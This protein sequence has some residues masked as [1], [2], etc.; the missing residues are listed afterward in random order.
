[1]IEFAA[2]PS[3]AELVG[4][5]SMAESRSGSTPRQPPQTPAKPAE[6]S[7]STAPAASGEDR[8]EEKRQAEQPRTGTENSRQTA[9]GRAPAGAVKPGASKPSEAEVAS[10]TE[11]PVF[12][13]PVKETSIYVVTVDNRTG[14]AT[15]IERLNDETGERKE[16][17]VSEYAQATAHSSLSTPPAIPPTSPGATP[18]SSEANALV[19]AYLQGMIDYYK[20]YGAG[21]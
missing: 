16:L 21:Q 19:Q 14:L 6:P 10:A 5:K 9:E 8:A 2:G 18:Y 3:P 1:V 20:T 17:S 11:K 12:N 13:A 7:E 4:A 15:K